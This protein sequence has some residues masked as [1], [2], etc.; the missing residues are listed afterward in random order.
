ME[1]DIERVLGHQR[2]NLKKGIKEPVVEEK[3]KSNNESSG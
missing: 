3:K 2:D 1:K